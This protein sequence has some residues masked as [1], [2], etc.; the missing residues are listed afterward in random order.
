MISSMIGSQTEV[1]SKDV[2]RRIAMIDPKVAQDCQ[3]RTGDALK[4]S[5]EKIDTVAL[6]WPA[7]Q[8]DYGKGLIR[9]DG[10]LRNNL[11]G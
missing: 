10:Y 9:I 2:R 4:I 7:R 6:S 3:I 5:S 11:D 8:D 1:G